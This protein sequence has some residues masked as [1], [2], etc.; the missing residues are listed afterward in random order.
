MCCSFLLS[1]S[2]ANPNNN[3]PSP[4]S[5]SHSIPTPSLFFLSSSFLC[6]FLKEK[7]YSIFIFRLLK[8]TLFPFLLVRRIACG[9]APILYTILYH[10]HH[11]YYYYY[12]RYTTPT[13]WPGILQPRLSSSLF[14][15]LRCPP[16]SNPCPPTPSPW[17]RPRPPRPL[18]RTRSATSWVIIAPLSHVVSFFF[19]VLIYIPCVADQIVHCRRRKIRCLV[20]ADDAHGRCENCIRLRK[21]CQFFPVDQQP[22]I[23]KKS[24]PNSRL[25]SASTDP[26]TAS[27]SPPI[28]S[29]RPDQPPHQHQHQHPP[30][31]Q[32]EPFFTYQPIPLSAS[33]DMSGLSSTASFAPENPMSPFAPGW[34]PC[35]IRHAGGHA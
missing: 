8:H 11:Y 3:L 27:S 24:R 35:Y 20:A 13:A 22:P 12:Y 26:S 1:F 19:L 28:I 7:N 4:I 30:H 32:P 18:P 34:Y 5:S 33:Q 9:V 6:S 17:T 2:N 14:L 16:W 21:E 31:P 10:H 29:G 15:F 25:E 23:E